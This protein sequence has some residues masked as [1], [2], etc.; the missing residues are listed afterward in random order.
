MRKN[1]A[2]LLEFVVRL[3]GDVAPAR[4]LTLKI[5]QDTAMVDG[6]G[7]EI[8]S[9]SY[10]LARYLEQN[11]DLRGKRV[12][13]LGAG[14]GLVGL[15]CAARGASFVM[16]TDEFPDLLEVNAELN[17]PLLETP[18]LSNPR[19]LCKEAVWSSSVFSNDQDVVGLHY[20]LGSDITQLGRSL[21]A[22]LAGAIRSAI[23]GQ[24][25]AVRNPS[26]PNSVSASDLSIPPTDALEIIVM[27]AMDICSAECMGLCTSS[28]CAASHFRTAM[29]SQGFRAHRIFSCPIQSNV[30]V[31]E[32]RDARG[33][34][35]VIDE[36]GVCGIFEFRSK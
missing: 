29:A 35:L 23:D 21:H 12:L 8:W 20:I 15:T 27:I 32:G 7:G 10:I 36:E 30:A 14:C 26:L 28:R 5:R 3:P 18:S 6:L 17:R 24:C 25:S 13:E 22:E 9:S 11:V 33:R 31:A 19:I 1:G 34:P 16:L 4:D 2:A